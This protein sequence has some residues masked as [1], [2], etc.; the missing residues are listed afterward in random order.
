MSYCELV[1]R[2]LFWRQSLQRRAE[3]FSEID[4]LSLVLQEETSSLEMS[5]SL[6]E[7]LQEFS[8]L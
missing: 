8:V 3:S 1:V 5:S 2:D 7:I 4:R 6:C